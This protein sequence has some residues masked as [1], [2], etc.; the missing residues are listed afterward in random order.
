MGLYARLRPF[1]TNITAIALLA[2]FVGSYSAAVPAPRAA[3][4]TAPDNVGREFYLA[5]GNFGSI[6][7]PD[8]GNLHEPMVYIAS[9]SSQTANGTLEIA[10]GSFAPVAFSVAP[11]AVT[12]VKIPPTGRVLGVDPVNH[13]HAAP[14]G[15]SQKSFRI[16][17]DNDISVYFLNYVDYSTDAAVLL[18]SDAVGSLYVIPSYH[19]YGSIEWDGM[20]LIV[21]Q[22]DDTVVTISASDG[23]N[24]PNGTPGSLPQLYISNANS[25]DESTQ[26]T[27]QA[28]DVYLGRPATDKDPSGTVVRSDKPVAV[29][30]GSGCSDVP[31]PFGAC[32]QL[33]DAVPSVDTWGTE[34]I[35][36]AAEGRNLSDT[37]RVFAWAD[38]TEVRIDGEL[39][40]TLDG[41][42]WLEYR[43]ASTDA[44]HIETSLPAMAVRY[45][46]GSEYDGA[47]GDPSMTVMQPLSQ[48][49]LSYVLTTP[50]DM[51]A[52]LGGDT[53]YANRIGIVAPDSATVNLDGSPV[54]T[55]W[56]AVGDSGYRSTVIDVEPAVYTLS[57]DEPFQTIVYGVRYLESY[58][59]IGGSQYAVTWLPEWG[60]AYELLPEEPTPAVEPTPEPSCD[61]L[62]DMAVS[63][64]FINLAPGGTATVE[65]ALRNLCEDAPFTP[66]DLLVSLSDGLTVIDG[67]GGMLNLGQRAAWQ[68]LM[69]KPGETRQFT[70]VVQAPAQFSTA[71]LHIS[72]LYYSGRVA[73][74]IDGVFITPAPAAEPAVAEAAVEPAPVVTA[75]PAALPTV[76]PNTAAPAGSML[77]LLLAALG[78]LSGAVLL[79][80]RR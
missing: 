38:G 67:S 15:L 12:A 18:P 76:L 75:V 69:L 60:G 63:P 19:G 29:F 9:A 42:T 2:V 28:G 62:P 21:A 72:E 48:N 35:A 37:F 13:P 26:M 77:P 53:E 80:R 34:Y 32:D 8:W 51:V 20:Y 25:F 31:A 74:R 59:Y 49:R 43:R 41:G 27:L 45:L 70:L 66:F 55:G 39:I 78:G 57:A 17:S 16:S 11:G 33:L 65:V 3:A 79:L 64:Q 1:L 7:Q 54:T 24:A 73:N 58:A 22:E 47:A 44:M 5:S 56:A 14:D 36:S 30:G 40:A 68:Q 52:E 4:Q 46:N 50:V 61:E 6:A 71:P 23:T 10:D